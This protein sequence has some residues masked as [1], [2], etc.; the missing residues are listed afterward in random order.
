LEVLQ[1]IEPARKVPEEA[2]L[3]GSSRSPARRAPR[4]LLGRLVLLIEEGLLDPMALQC[5]KRETLGQDPPSLLTS[6][7]SSSFGMDENRAP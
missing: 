4:R 3:D 5:S 2:F 1:A 6:L 7:F